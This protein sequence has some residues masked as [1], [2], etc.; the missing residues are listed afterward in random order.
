MGERSVGR[1]IDCCFMFLKLTF[2]FSLCIFQI[3]RLNRVFKEYAIR[4]FALR[5]AH[6]IIY[7]TTRT[8]LISHIR[9]I[10]EIFS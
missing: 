6:F 2:N 3:G 9:L 5:S 7:A 10:L 8:P 4:I 1:N